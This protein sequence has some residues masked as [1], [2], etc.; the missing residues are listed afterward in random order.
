MSDTYA[1]SGLPSDVFN[2]NKEGARRIKVEA[3]L[4]DEINDPASALIQKDFTYNGDGTVDTI[5]ETN[6]TTLIQTRK[7]F[8]YSSGELTS[9]VPTILP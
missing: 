3:T 4:L 6:L 1:L 7:Q 5:T 8:N 2:S 9:I